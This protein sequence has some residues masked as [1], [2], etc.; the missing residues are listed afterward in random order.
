MCSRPLSEIWRRFGLSRLT[1]K[2]RLLR[3]HQTILYIVLGW[4]IASISDLGGIFTS[5]FR[6]SVIYMG[7]GLPYHTIYYT[8]IQGTGYCT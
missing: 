7:Y 2:V 8:Y 3:T 1:Q 4:S 5:A 6:A